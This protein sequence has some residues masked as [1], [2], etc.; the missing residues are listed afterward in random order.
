MIILYLFIRSFVNPFVDTSLTF[1]DSS[2]NSFSTNTC[3]LLFEITFLFNFFSLLSKS[4]F[5]RKL[6]I[7]L[8]LGKFSCVNLAVKFFSVNLLNSWILIYLSWSWSVVILFSVLLILCY[9]QFSLSK[10]L[11]LG[12]LFPTA[13]RAVVV[14]KLVI[15]DTLLLTSFILALRAVIAAKLVILDIPF[16]SLTILA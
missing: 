5:S 8:L 13:V 2:F 15:L 11:T 7:S 14:A 16:L 10:L 1:F 4:V 12:I 3:F 9:S 6:A